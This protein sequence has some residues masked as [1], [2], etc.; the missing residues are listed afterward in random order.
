MYD[1]DKDTIKILPAE[2]QHETVDE[3]TVMTICFTG[4][5]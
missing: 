5:I 3:V 2:Y 1:M 4:H